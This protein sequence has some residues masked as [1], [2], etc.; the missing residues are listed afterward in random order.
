MSATFSRDKPTRPNAV[1]M[2][3][4]LLAL[5]IA[6]LG[7]AGGALAEPS[8]LM[9]AALR[10]AVSARTVLIATAIGSFCIRYNSDGTM[11]GRAPAL[12]AGPWG[13]REAWANGGSP[14]AVFASVGTNGSTQ[15]D[16]ASSC[17]MSAPSFIGCAMTACPAR[18]PSS[19]GSKAAV[20]RLAPR[21]GGRYTMGRLS[22]S[23]AHWR[24]RRPPHWGTAGCA[25]LLLARS[26][27]CIGQPH[28]SVSS[29]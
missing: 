23:A 16:T 22:L 11:T 10:Q 27:P 19:A 26:A 15:R 18:P 4:L 9:G 14:T 25:G 6:P 8:K 28:A 13:R 12:V 5:L 24:V 29:L 3:P 20:D 21:T 7:L 1:L 2:L 17:T